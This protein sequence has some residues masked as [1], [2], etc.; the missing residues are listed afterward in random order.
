MADDGQSGKDAVARESLRSTFKHRRPIMFLGILLIA[1]SV[2]FYFHSDSNPG[3]EPAAFRDQPPQYINVYETKP[4]IPITVTVTLGQGFFSVNYDRYISPIKLQAGGF[5]GFYEVVAVQADAAGSGGPGTIILTSS[6]RPLTG[7]AAADAG[8]IPPPSAPGRGT[9][10]SGPIFRFAV[11]VPL[12]KVQGNTWLGS[13]AFGS[14]PII[15][16]D[17]GSIFGHLPS[18]GAYDYL[19]PPTD[20]LEAGYDRRTGQLKKVASGPF[21]V[22]IPAGERT[23]SFGC[24]YNISHYTEVID[25]MVP[26]LKDEQIDYTIPSVNSGGDIDYTWNSN[27]ISGLEPIFKATNPDAVDSQNQAAFISGIAFGVAGAAAIA[28]IQ[29]LPKDPGFKR[30]RKS[31]SQDG[32]TAKRGAE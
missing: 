32:D 26:A 17:N 19:R 21:G 31:P 14:V 24:P 6:S 15:F 27:G 5:T 22:G 11:P 18:V 9:G 4:Q 2:G 10:H 13:V 8:E 29:E 28:I 30:R 1:L 23:E 3:T 25:N 12:I 20:C 16:Q 7:R